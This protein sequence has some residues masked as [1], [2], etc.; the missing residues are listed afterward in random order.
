MTASTKC[1]N[2]GSSLPIPCF[3]TNLIASGLDSNQLVLADANPSE[4]G[5]PFVQD[6]EDEVG[7]AIKD[8]QVLTFVEAGDNPRHDVSTT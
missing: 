7:A 6:Q 3:R 8:R 2:T 4:A 1:G 5:K